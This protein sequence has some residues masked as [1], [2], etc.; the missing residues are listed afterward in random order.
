M[1]KCIKI[2][3]KLHRYLDVLY[4][5]VLGAAKVVFKEQFVALN[6]NIR[7]EENLKPS[8]PSS[9]LKNQKVITEDISEIEKCV[10]E[11]PQIQALI[12]GGQKK[13]IGILTNKTDTNER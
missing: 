8:K 10:L 7:K 2:H 4:P 9:Q 5:H 13:L 6:V 11:N 12:E 1:I 3:D